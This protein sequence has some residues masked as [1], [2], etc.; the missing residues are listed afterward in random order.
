[1]AS[2]P[3]S[4]RRRHA[5]AGLTLFVALAAPMAASADSIFDLFLPSVSP[6]AVQYNLARAGFVARSAMVRRGD[7]YLYDVS[8]RY[9]VPQRLVIDAR[10]GRI[11]ERYSLRPSQWAEARRLDAR[12][13]VEDDWD[14]EWDGSPR[15]E[16]DAPSPRPHVIEALPSENLPATPR[17]SRQ[18]DLAYGEGHAATPLVATPPPDP[19]PTEKPRIKLSRPRPIASPTPGDQPQTAT[20]APSATDPAAPQATTAPLGAPATTRIAPT[21][22]QPATASPTPTTSGIVASSGASDAKAAP[23]PPPAA[24]GKAINDIPVAPLD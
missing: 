4:T 14:A 20:A 6:S 11:M 19:K 23:P 5:F 24:K 18:R 17:L 22:Q 13:R 21:P 8:D 9:G 16:I 15:P 3:I 7:V 2:K 10:T 1:M 12:P